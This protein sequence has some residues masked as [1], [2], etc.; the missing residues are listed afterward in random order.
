MAGGHG[1]SH[2]VSPWPPPPPRP[3]SMCDRPCNHTHLA[4]RNLC[5]GDNASANNSMF[6][7]VIKKAALVTRGARV[8]LLS[9]V[10][11][12]KEKHT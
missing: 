10:R 11:T 8:S 1:T 3:L 5:I 12:K 9:S 6:I 2:C 7:D 4:G